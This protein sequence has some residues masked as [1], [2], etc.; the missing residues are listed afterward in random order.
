[1]CTIQYNTKRENYLG[2]WKVLEKPG[3]PGFVLNLLVIHR[4]LSWVGCEDNTNV[5]N[6]TRFKY[7]DVPIF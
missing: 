2:T 5:R 3:A 7:S 1:M 6:E 4:K